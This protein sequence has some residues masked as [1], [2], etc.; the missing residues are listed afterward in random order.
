M[1]HG[2]SAYLNFTGPIGGI[3]KFG[4][5]FTWP[6]SSSETVDPNIIDIFYLP[7]LLGIAMMMMMNSVFIVILGL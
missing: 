7:E 4:K 6:I 1:G 5:Y 2:S 3:T